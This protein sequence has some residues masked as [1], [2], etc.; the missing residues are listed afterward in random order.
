[1]TSGAHD[2]SNRKYY[3]QGLRVP[4][5]EVGSFAPLVAGQRI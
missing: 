2:G 4:A 3:F 5:S 1:M